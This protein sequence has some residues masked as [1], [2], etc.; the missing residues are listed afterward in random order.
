MKHNIDFLELPLHV[1][2]QGY[3]EDANSFT[4]LICGRE[5]EKGRIYKEGDNLYEAGYFMKVHIGRNHGSIFH[6]LLGLDKKL[7]GL[8]EHQ[9][10]LLKRFYAGISD[11]QIQKDLQ[12]GSVSTIRN[13]RFALKEKERQARIFMTIME[14]MKENETTRPRYVQPHA[15]ATMIDDRYKITQD[16][17]EKLL[18]K[19]FPDGLDGCL[20]TFVL[21]EKSKLVVLRHIASKIEPGR[22]YTEKEINEILTAIY[23]DHV[24]IRRYLIEYGF[25]DRKPDCSAYWLRSKD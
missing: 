2:K 24:T 12:I 20:K 5:I 21:K 10:E 13:H 19:Y 7:T 4:C 22:I 25:L 16:E 3:T 9:C 23:H 1:V 8:S 18:K 11:Q 6:Y 17:N 14:L 15:T